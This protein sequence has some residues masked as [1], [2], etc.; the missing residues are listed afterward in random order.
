M[1]QSE[2]SIL[3]RAVVRELKLSAN[4]PPDDGRNSPGS[5]P[6]WEVSLV[7][8]KVLSGPESLV[9]SMM[10]TLSANSLPDGNERVVTPK[11]NIGETGIWA[12]KRLSNGKLR[13]IYNPYEV[14]KDVYLPLIKGRHD[15]YFRV[16]ERLSGDRIVPDSATEQSP[17]QEK[18]VQTTPE[19][20]SPAVQQSVEKKAPTPSQKPALIDAPISL[21]SWRIIGVLIVVVA[22]LLWVL[23]KRRS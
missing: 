21:M 15:A 8:D 22:G 9:G 17:Q 4:S 3:V 5:P 16:L 2:E 1:S 19:P 10:Y 18:S 20:L 23:F 11:L 12:I 13:E 6:L 14:E 7:I